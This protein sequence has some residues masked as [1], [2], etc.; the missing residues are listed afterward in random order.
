MPK[1]LDKISLIKQID[2]ASMLETISDTPQHLEKTF[3]E[4]SQKDIS[5]SKIN[6]IV[7]FGLG[8]SAIAGEL[9]SQELFGQSRVP[10]V[11][12]KRGSLPSFVNKNTLCFALSYSGNTR[13]TLSCY[14]EAIKKKVKVIAITSGGELERLSTRNKNLVVKLPNNF[15]PR[16]ALGL[17]TGATLGCLEKTGLFTK[18]L[19]KTVKNTAKLLSSL[20]K[21]YDLNVETSKNL[22][23]RIAY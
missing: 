1:E 9:I 14:K 16:A 3:S 20:A 18:S 8:G 4:A 7:F 13:E 21:D 5:F 23:K 2:K 6:S 17:L 11:V 19:A 10:A 15:Q 22:A 12:V